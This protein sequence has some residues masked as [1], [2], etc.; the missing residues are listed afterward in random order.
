MAQAKRML[1]FNKLMNIAKYLN[2]D[3]KPDF[4][5]HH[6][7]WNICKEGD[8]YFALWTDFTENCSVYFKSEEAACEAVRLMGKDSLNDLFSTDW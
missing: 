1:A 5:G 8:D 4:D 2:G 3:W 7:N 6:K